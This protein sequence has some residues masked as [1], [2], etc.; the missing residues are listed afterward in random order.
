MHPALLVK[1]WRDHWRGL[2]AWSVGLA[3]IT[4][5]QLSVYPSV[6]ESSAEMDTLLKNWPDV[7]QGMFS[8]E[9]YTTGPGFLNVELFSMMVPLVLIAVA[10][11]WGASATADEE[12]NGTADILLTLPV[13][14]TSVIVTKMLAAIGA[15]VVLALVTAAVIALGGPMVEIEIPFATLLRACLGSALLGLVFGA[16]AFL[17]GA[18]TGKRAVS[19]GVAI[20]LALASFLVKSLSSMV[21]TFDAINPYN[22]FTWAL[23]GNPLIDALQP[24]SAA[25]LALTSV[26][27][28]VAAVLAFQRRD[29]S[30]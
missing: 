21:D 10:V 20:G 27:L 3:A 2:L 24:S 29:I 7:F 14:R 13:S 11:S 15:L 16:V 28:L 5:V 8:F 9:D 19:M 25:W 4:I 1:T 6:R 12:R 22:P 26:A 23:H 18:L 17:L 30:S